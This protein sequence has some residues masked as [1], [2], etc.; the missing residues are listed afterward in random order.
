M[1][2]SSRKTTNLQI[3]AGNRAF[4]LAVFVSDTT[5]KMAASGNFC[6][7][8]KLTIRQACPFHAPVAEVCRVR[9]LYPVKDLN[10]SSSS[11]FSF[12]FFLFFLFFFLAK[13]LKFTTMTPF[14]QSLCQ[15]MFSSFSLLL[16]LLVWL[17]GAGR[18]TFAFRRHAPFN[19]VHF[20]HT[21]AWR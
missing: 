19:L 8:P 20:Q 9:E 5:T 16:M 18:N 7:C 1:E 13:A 3:D 2:V 10:F 4:A 11:Y 21:E 14:K 6:S 12:F 17:F 15:S